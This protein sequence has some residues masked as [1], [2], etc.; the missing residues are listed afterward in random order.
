M[1]TEKSY[2]LRGSP[3]LFQKSH[4]N[5]IRKSFFLKKFTDRRGP[6]PFAEKNPKRIS[7]N[8]YVSRKCQSKFFPISYFVFFLSDLMLDFLILYFISYAI[9]NA[10]ILNAWLSSSCQRKIISIWFCEC[11]THAGGHTTP[12]AHKCLVFI[13]K[14]VMTGLFTKGHFNLMG[15]SQPA[16]QFD[17]KRLTKGGRDEKVKI[18]QL[19]L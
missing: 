19:K 1:F 12:K 16:Q 18:V 15:K 7:D 5:F 11:V 2:G 13:R 8:P 17:C 10:C 4:K 3:S 9:Y 14:Q 6:L